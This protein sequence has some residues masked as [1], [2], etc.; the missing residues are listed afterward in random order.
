MSIQQILTARRSII[1]K[2]LARIDKELASAPEGKLIVY[3]NL[4]KKQE[5]FQAIPIDQ[6]KLP[7]N[8][9]KKTEGNR[10]H[11]HKR[12]R[13]RHA[14][15]YLNKHMTGLAQ[16]L[17][18]KTL[19]LARQKDLLLE[20]S[21]IDSI[22]PSLNKPS[23]VE[24]ILRNKPVI[25][26]LVKMR[27]GDSDPSLAHE[28]EVWNKEPHQPNPRYAEHLT[29]QSVNG[30]FV[31]SKSEAMIDMLLTTYGIPFR[32]EGSICINGVTYHPDF[33]IRHPETGDYYLWEHFGMIDDEG[34]CR[35]NLPKIP[36]YANLGF[37][38]GRNMILTFETGD[39]PLN[40]QYV[41][42]LIK[43]YFLENL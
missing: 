1:Q 33:T 40:M 7:A 29:V 2:E 30:Y 18:Y 9:S 17:A 22:L 8:H 31:R 34:Y 3:N 13:T 41:E 28:L 37:I 6:K 24:L 20:M 11:K 36:L 14:R 21:A 23:Q 42:D 32:Y 27:T 38:P 10:P 4:K 12:K 19:L 16:E 5:L 39:Q 35:R 25:A 15:I 43:Y 26:S